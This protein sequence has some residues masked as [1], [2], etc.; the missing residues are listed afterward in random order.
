MIYADCSSLPITSVNALRPC[1]K[2]FSIFFADTKTL[3]HC[4]TLAAHARGVMT[5]TG[6]CCEWA[7][8]EGYNSTIYIILAARALA[9]LQTM[10]RLAHTCSTKPVRSYTH[11]VF[12]GQK[13]KITDSVYRTPVTVSREEF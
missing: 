10:G 3:R 9:K 1:L 12:Y 11:R 5:T 6:R 2:Y 13:G 7:G 8:G 4:F